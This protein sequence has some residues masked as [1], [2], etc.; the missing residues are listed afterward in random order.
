MVSWSFLGIAY[1]HALLQLG[2]LQ[3]EW[4]QVLFRF[5]L[6]HVVDRDGVTFVSVVVAESMKC[7]VYYRKVNSVLALF[8]HVRRRLRR[9]PVF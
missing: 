5:S 9:T 7:L 8:F 1:R 3:H 2:M 4:G 6:A